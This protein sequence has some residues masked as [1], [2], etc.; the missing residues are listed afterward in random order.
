MGDFALHN[1]NAVGNSA[2]GSGA[3]KSNHTGTGNTAIGTLALA[4]NIGGEENTATGI[5]ALSNSD[6]IRNTADGAGALQDNTTGIENTAVG[7]LTLPFN[8]SGSFN[9]AL[10][11]GAGQFVTTASNVICIGDPGLNV[12]NSC[13]IGNIWAQPGGSQAVFVN[14]N[15]KLGAQ[16]CSR[17]FKHDIEPMDSASEALLAF[18]PVTFRY[19]KEIDPAGTT[20][21]G[22][23]AEDVEKVNPGLVIRDKHGEPYSVRYDQVNAMLLNEFLKAHRKIEE[24]EQTISQLK[25]GMEALTAMVKEQTSQ[26][27]RV[28]A[29]LEL[30]K[31]A[32]QTVLNN[33]WSS[34]AGE[35]IGKSSLTISAKP[36]GVGAVCQPSIVPGE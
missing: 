6:G 11:S 4:S 21:F 7:F 26:L 17:R 2:F 28:S 33:H 16:V 27:Q 35:V 20:Q 14:S 5:D 19:N 24:Q 31:P 25:S 32:P 30:S 36:D 23:V 12:D 1:N 34:G 3:L 22:L 29:E 9:V 18:K 8:T 13:F 10:G 15:G